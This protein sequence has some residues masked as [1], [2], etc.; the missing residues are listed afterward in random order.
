VVPLSGKLDR[1]DCGRLCFA[2]KFYILSDIYGLT[3]GF[4]VL[5]QNYSTKFDS[6]SGET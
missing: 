3:T 5:Q 1:G 4:A 2:R 6:L